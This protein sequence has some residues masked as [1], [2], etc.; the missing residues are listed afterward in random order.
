MDHL[1]EAKEY[2][3]CANCVDGEI[4]AQLN[5]LLAIAH[6]GIAI[7]GRLPLPAEPSSVHIARLQREEQNGLQGNTE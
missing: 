3:R 1:T 7:C 4:F 5:A 6:I 2:A